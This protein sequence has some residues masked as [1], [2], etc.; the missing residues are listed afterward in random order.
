[1]WQRMH[2]C[3]FA[4][5]WPRILCGRAGAS[6]RGG[7][8]YTPDLE[9]DAAS[10]NNTAAAANGTA[11]VTTTTTSTTTTSTTIG[12][13]NGHGGGGGSPY[14]LESPERSLPSGTFELFAAPKAVFAVSQRP[15]GSPSKLHYSLGVTVK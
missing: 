12:N 13:A 10:A 7:G 6:A 8:A 2:A 3:G 15:D 9:T 1:M 14:F 4:C 5:M 11:A